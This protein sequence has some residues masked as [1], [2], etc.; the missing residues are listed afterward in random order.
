MSLAVYAMSN[1][2]SSQTPFIHRVYYIYNT[3]I[4]LFLMS[5]DTYA[6]TSNLSP[7]TSIAS[8]PLAK[9][10]KVI[11]YAIIWSLFLLLPIR[12]MMYFL[13]CRDISFVF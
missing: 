11:R 7:V 6:M 8:K 4:L 5:V 9:S 12:N 13:G 10:S 1:N 2:F 3:V